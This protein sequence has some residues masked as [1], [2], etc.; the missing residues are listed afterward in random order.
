MLKSPLAGLNV[1]LLEDDA[2]L[3]RRLTGFLEG[4]KAEVTAV[5]TVAA[6]RR[7]LEDLAFEAALIDV[8]LPD[9]FGTDLLRAKAFPPT[10][11]VIVMTAEGGVNGAIE[12]L[13]AGA[14][15]YLLKPFDP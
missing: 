1:L 12:A 3:R 14:A 10:T 11:T 2:L 7:A 8:N 5:N 15:D 9:G 13:R 4:E 6:A